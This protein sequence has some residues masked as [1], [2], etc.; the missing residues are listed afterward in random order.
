[1]LSTKKFKFH[2]KTHD[3]HRDSQCTMA[4]KHPSKVS[5][6]NLSEVCELFNDETHSFHYI[7]EQVDLHTLRKAG[8]L[9]ARVPRHF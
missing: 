4:L 3:C 8:K 6:I 1:M 9:S 7:K 5:W 2:Y